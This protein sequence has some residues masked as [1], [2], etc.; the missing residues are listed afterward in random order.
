MG[1]TLRG[2]DEHK[3]DFAM[4]DQKTLEKVGGW[5]LGA[6]RVVEVTGFVE[7]FG[8]RHGPNHCACI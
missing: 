7:L 3:G 5:G 6:D 1:G 4:R 2:K 8:V